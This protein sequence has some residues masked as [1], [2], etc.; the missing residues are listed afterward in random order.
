MSLRNFMFMQLA[1]VFGA[2]APLFVA[3]CAGLIAKTLDC[4]LHEG[5]ENPCVVYGID[6][7]QLLYFANVIGW[8]TMVS[9]PAGAVLWLVHIC[10]GLFSFVKWCRNGRAA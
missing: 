4:E 3:I 1:I 8:L 5:F 6:I 10:Y 7:G 9:I 2:V